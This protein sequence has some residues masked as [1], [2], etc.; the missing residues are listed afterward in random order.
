MADASS[1]LRRVVG[2]LRARA[3][4][5]PGRSTGGG[6]DPGVAAALEAEQQALTEPVPDDVEELRRRRDR[7]P[8]PSIERAALDERLREL[9]GGSTGQATDPD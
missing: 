9:E 2:F 4:A 7:A 1:P 6:V 3:G 8:L 5:L